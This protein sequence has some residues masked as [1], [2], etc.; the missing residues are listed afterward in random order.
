MPN[1]GIIYEKG[2]ELVRDEEQE[3]YFRS[4][5]G[6]RRRLADICSSGVYQS[7]GLRPIVVAAELRGHRSTTLLLPTDDDVDNVLMANGPAFFTV[8]PELGFEF[9]AQQISF[10]ID[11]DSVWQLYD[12]QYLLGAVAHHCKKLAEIYSDICHVH[13][14]LPMPRTAHTPTILGRFQEPWY[15]F[16]ALITA[17]RR[18]YD[19]MRHVVWSNY[20]SK[21]S[22]PRSLTATLRDCGTRIP[23]TLRDRL[24]ESWD[25]YGKKLTD[26]RDCI[27]HYV[28]LDF[29]M[30]SIVMRRISNGPCTAFVRIP[31]NPE[32]RSRRDF[33]YKLDLDAQTY[34]WEIAKELLEVSEAVTEP[35]Q[36]IKSASDHGFS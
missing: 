16:D 15:E 34:G 27:Q 36:G 30:A 9:R 2:V 32:T 1:C 14:C 13:D 23:A 21:G 11:Q 4:I 19:S 31:D 3:W 6:K 25:R 35:I 24:E 33:Q 10:A 8:P 28:S 22:T 26:Y 17:A 7:Y 5:Q 20:G 18:T 12:L 29:A